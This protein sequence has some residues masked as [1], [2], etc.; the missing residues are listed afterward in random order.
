MRIFSVSG[1]LIVKGIKAW[2][3]FSLIRITPF[4]PLDP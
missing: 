2:D 3:Y 4:A 1:F